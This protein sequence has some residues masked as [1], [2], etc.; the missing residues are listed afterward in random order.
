MAA[1]PK[2]PPRDRSAD[3]ERLAAAVFPQLLAAARGQKTVEHIAREA[4][5]VA[6]AFYATIDTEPKG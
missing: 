4:L 5:D 3:V 1:D 2:K 6:R